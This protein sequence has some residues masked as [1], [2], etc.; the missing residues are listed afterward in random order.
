MKKAHFV[1]D[2]ATVDTSRMIAAARI[3]NVV[4]LVFLQRYEHRN[5]GL[6]V[7]GG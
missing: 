3:I 7:P 1:E 6:P 2:I 5:G 4:L